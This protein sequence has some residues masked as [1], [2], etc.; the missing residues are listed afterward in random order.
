METNIGNI[1]HQIAKH[2]THSAATLPRSEG[3]DL[4]GAKLRI[5]LS[6]MEGAA[7]VS[8]ADIWSAPAHEELLPVFAR[9]EASTPVPHFP[10]PRPLAMESL[11]AAPDHDCDA[12]PVQKL[13]TNRRD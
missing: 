1:E 8:Q 13:C 2:P 12:L 3:P 4:D 5:R 7:R 10:P 9:H 6:L 11:R